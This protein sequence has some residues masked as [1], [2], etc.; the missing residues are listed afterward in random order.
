MHVSEFLGDGGDETDVMAQEKDLRIRL[1]KIEA[2]R[3]RADEILT[4]PIDDLRPEEIITE[5]A[6][7][8]LAVMQV[9]LKSL[10]PV[11]CLVDLDGVTSLERENAQRSHAL[12]ERGQP[13]R[14][15]IASVNTEGKSWRRTAVSQPPRDNREF[16]RYIESVFA[17]LSERGRQI[18]REQTEVGSQESEAEHARRV[19]SCGLAAKTK[20]IEELSTAV[21]QRQNASAQIVQAREMIAEI[22]TVYDGLVDERE[23]LERRHTTIERDSTMNRSMAKSIREMK[24]RLNAKRFAIERKEHELEVRRSAINRQSMD[25][26]T[27]ERGH[28]LMLTRDRAL[29]DE[30]QELALRHGNIISVIQEEFAELSESRAQ[31]TSF[32]T[33]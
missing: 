3:A 18:E 15:V 5:E 22:Q 16:I 17:E 6:E 8:R 26:D 7:A 24:H 21:Q 2:R 4:T 14:Q 23:R 27:A 31:Q 19:H 1:E 20:T 30:L 28:S 12:R 10:S 32:Q 13:R 11:S 29:D 25:V 33:D 9:R